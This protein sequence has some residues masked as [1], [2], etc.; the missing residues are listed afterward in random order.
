M[1]TDADKHGNRGVGKASPLGSFGPLIRE[2]IHLDATHDLSSLPSLI[3]RQKYCA[4]RKPWVSRLSSAVG[5]GML[6][7]D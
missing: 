2:S 4:S 7:I 5:G 3:S 1:H 6:E